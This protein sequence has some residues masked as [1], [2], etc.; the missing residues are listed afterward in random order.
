MHH[1]PHF[2]GYTD[3]PGP[4]HLPATLQNSPVL[5]KSY[6]LLTQLAGIYTALRQV[7]ALGPIFFSGI[8]G[9]AWYGVSGESWMNPA[10]MFGS[11]SFI[12][13]QGL[14]G[15][16]GGWWHQTFR[17]VFEPPATWVLQTLD[18]DKRSTPGKAIAAFVAFSLSGF[19]HAAGSYT[20][21]GDNHPLRGP[22]VFFLLQFL[23]VMAETLV[24]AQ[25]K[26]SGISQRTPRVLKQVANY[27]IVLVWMYLT[28][29]F[30]VDDFAQGG[31][32][33]HEPVPFSLVNALGYGAEG[34]SWW[35]WQGLVQWRWGKGWYD[36]GFTL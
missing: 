12:G 3:C 11:L 15:W 23:G 16:W 33:L 20:Q 35:C 22:T 10:N 32:W 29:P 34:D 14:A 21:L 18:I 13:E 8:L 2:W 28:A 9:P 5:L 4:S 1:D 27:I 31:I 6:R 19:L 36:T 25:L 26:R 7:F 17:S 24:K 30:L